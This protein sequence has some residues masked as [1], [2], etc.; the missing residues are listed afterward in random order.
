MKNS[1]LPIFDEIW[2]LILFL[3]MS[4]YALLTALSSLCMSLYTRLT[5]LSHFLC[6]CTPHWSVPLSLY[7][8]VCTPHCSVGQYDT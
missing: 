6:I 2:P 8:T 1:L 3:Y 5:A 7:V 4:L